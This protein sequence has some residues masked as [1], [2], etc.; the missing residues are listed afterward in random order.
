[1]NNI[2][3]RAAAQEDYPAAQKLHSLPGVIHG[4]LQ[5]PFPTLDLWKQRLS[6]LHERKGFFLV[7]TV[8]E[9]LLGML[10]LELW[11]GSLRRR[12]VGSFGMCVHD[13][14]QGKGIGNALM[15]AMLDLADNWLNLRRL[16]LQVFTD[17]ERAIRL[18]R[19]HGFEVEGTLRQYA[20]RN[21]A[22]AD[23]F[24]MARLGQRT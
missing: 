24:M 19:R 16:E 8:D 12:H 5:L 6:N 23:V 2:I 9:K 14:W 13:D 17:N 22:F 21:G 15:E 10:G 20:F 4:T 18:Y 7:A 11:E 1:M 3:V